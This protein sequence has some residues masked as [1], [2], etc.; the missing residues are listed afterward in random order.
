MFMFGIKKSTFTSPI[1]ND[2]RARK[3][4]IKKGSSRDKEVLTEFNIS[5]SSIGVTMYAISRT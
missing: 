5:S 2:N 3:F 4:V 1:A